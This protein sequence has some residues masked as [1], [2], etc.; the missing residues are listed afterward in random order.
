MQH[1]ASVQNPRLKSAAR[2][3]DRRGR[4]QQGR[5]LIDGLREVQRAW[6]AGV[7][8]EELFLPPESVAGNL[9]WLDELAARGVAVTTVAPV[10]FRKLAYGERAA[11]VVAVAHARQRTLDDLFPATSSPIDR[12]GTAA[13]LVVVLESVE[14]PGNIGAVSRTAVAAGATGLIVADPGTDLYNPNA[15]RSSLG[16][17]FD[18]PICAAAATE[19][20]AVLRR[21]RFQLFAARVSTER[22]Y[23]AVDYRGATAIVLGGEATGLSDVWRGQ[24]VVDVSIPM[25][26]SVDSLNVSVTAG[27]LL[28][29]VIRQRTGG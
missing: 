13:R 1:I 10:A 24:D 19:V 17:L 20:L 29:E 22:S 11:G 5:F 15:I 18:L 9:Q 14:K 4:Q 8:L 27:I 25:Q 7:E 16:A 2:L 12:E 3:R 28:Y 26:G 6:A 21:E 23:T